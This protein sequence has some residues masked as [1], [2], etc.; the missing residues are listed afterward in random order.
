MSYNSSFSSSPFLRW[1]EIIITRQKCQPF[2]P[3]KRGAQG[4]P[5]DKIRIKLDL[6]GFLSSSPSNDGNP[7]LVTPLYSPLKLRGDEGGLRVGV[8]IQI[9]SPFTSI[10]SPAFAEAPSRRQAPRGEEIFCRVIFPSNPAGLTGRE[11]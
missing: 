8:N 9:L 5:F 6:V 2:D 11:S 10:L 1:K 4:S 7:P 3:A